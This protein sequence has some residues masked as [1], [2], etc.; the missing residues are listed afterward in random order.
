MD[1]LK[2]ITVGIDEVG[3]GCLAGPIMI[4]AVCLPKGFNDACVK[5]SKTV[6]KSQMLRALTVIKDKALWWRCLKISVTTVDRIGTWAAWDK[7]VA[8]L[9]RGAQEFK[10]NA[11][12]IIDGTRVPD[13]V[14]DTV[15]VSTLKKGDT[16]NYAIAAASILA[17]CYRDRYM[18]DLDTTFPF[19][20]WGSNVGYGTPEHMAAI[21]EHG[22]TIH[23]RQAA[24]RTARLNKLRK[25]IR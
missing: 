15:M 1:R 22:L 20:G 13:T 8:K 10:D 7:G 3:I 5:D 9:V 2:R 4:A 18:Q 25:G 16:L 24:T 6:R 14:S 19:Y 12:I 17:K 23:H 11:P 21:D